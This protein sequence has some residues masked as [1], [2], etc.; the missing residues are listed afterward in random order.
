MVQKSWGIHSPFLQPR[1]V[2]NLD[3]FAVLSHLGVTLPN[4][5]EKEEGRRKVCVCKHVSHSHDVISTVRVVVSYLFSVNPGNAE[6]MELRIK[7]ISCFHIL[8]GGYQIA[9]S[10]LLAL[11]LQVEVQL[12]FAQGYDRE[13]WCVSEPRNGVQLDIALDK[14]F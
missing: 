5:V 12:S 13:R 4:W 11:T 7:L 2:E 9:D 3:S 14:S 8:C 1:P 10:S 6:P